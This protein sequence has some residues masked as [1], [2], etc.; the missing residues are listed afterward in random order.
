VLQ[1]WPRGLIK[2]HVT[3]V[4]PARHVLEESNAAMATEPAQHHVASVPARVVNAFIRTLLHM[5]KMQTTRAR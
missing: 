4:A 2:S 1:R 3:I 5:D